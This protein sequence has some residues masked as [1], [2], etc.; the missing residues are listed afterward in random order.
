MI[1]ESN[2]Y[3]SPKPNQGTIEKNIYKFCIAIQSNEL[4]EEGVPEDTQEL[5]AYFID[6]YPFPFEIETW[7]KPWVACG[8]RVVDSWLVLHQKFDKEKKVF[9]EQ[10]KPRFE[11]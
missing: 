6:E 10:W 3:R 1:P 2:S 8:Y 7:A 4:D 11:M 5:F 9:V